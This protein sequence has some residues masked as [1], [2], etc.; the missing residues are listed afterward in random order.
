LSVAIYRVVLF[1]KAPGGDVTHSVPFTGV[2]RVQR[3]YI[4]G[5]TKKKERILEGAQK[6]G[7]LEGTLEGALETTLEGATAVRWCGRGGCMKG[8]KEV[9]CGAKQLR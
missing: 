8:A 6:K 5:C 7:T 4:G 2:W 9:K 1:R 3:G